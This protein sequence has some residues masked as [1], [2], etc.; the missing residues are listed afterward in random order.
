MGNKDEKAGSG[1]RK[2]KIEDYGLLV[3][4]R[5]DI[6]DNIILK[7]LIRQLLAENINID[8]YFQKEIDEKLIEFKKGE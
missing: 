2:F 6:W 7:K 4:Y 5:T 3:I 8:D 1:K